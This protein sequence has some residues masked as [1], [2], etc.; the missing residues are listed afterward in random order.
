M[1]FFFN[2][3]ILISVKLIEFVCIYN[4]IDSKQLSIIFNKQI[5]ELKMIFFLIFPMQKYL[6]NFIMI[7]C[8]E[9]KI[10]PLHLVCSNL[11]NY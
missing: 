1:V 3:S 2:S 5:N 10:N 4:N 6:T 11:L 8:N 7:L 9:Y